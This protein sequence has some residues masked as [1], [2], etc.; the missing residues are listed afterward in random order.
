MVN[1]ILLMSVKV[2]TLRPLG[3]PATGN[4][5]FNYMFL[6]FKR[7]QELKHKKHSFYLFS[8]SGSYLAAK[9]LIKYRFNEL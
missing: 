7:F 6:P 8:C 9:I 1:S 4:G 2:A 3:K 5:L